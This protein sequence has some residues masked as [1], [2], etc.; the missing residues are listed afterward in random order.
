MMKRAL[1]DLGGTL[2]ATPELLYGLW[3]L[4]RLEHPLATVFGGRNTPI[5]SLYYDKA[6]ELGYGIAT[7]G[8]S[9]L[10]GGGA[11][12]MEAALCGALK[13][14]PKHGMGIGVRGLDRSYLPHCHQ[15]TIFVHDFSLRKMLLVHYSSG[16]IVCP[17]GYGTLDEFFYTLT[18]IK[19]KQIASVPVILFGSEFWEPLL[20]W[21]FDTPVHRK[22]IAQYGINLF[23][24]IDDVDEACKL[25]HI[26]HRPARMP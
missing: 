20:K 3:R 23:T 22:L 21:M 9:L 16:I 10:T 24:L 15:A 25:L 5:D 7:H 11:G 12:I 4:S 6:K 17:G 26:H 8:F 19:T 14:G 1:Y 18:L 2:L 13:V